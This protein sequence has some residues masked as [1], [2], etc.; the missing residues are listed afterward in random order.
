[1]P[2]IAAETQEAISPVVFGNDSWEDKG[3]G[4][5]DG[6]GDAVGEAVGVRVK[7]GEGIGEDVGIGVVSVVSGVL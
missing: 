4:E 7:A 3:L 5:G 6:E 2:I 1:M